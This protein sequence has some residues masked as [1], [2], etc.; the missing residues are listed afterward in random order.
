[1]VV[2]CNTTQSL[3][4]H[5]F[6]PQ[7]PLEG[8]ILLGFIPESLRP[9][10]SLK[11]PVKYNW[12]KYKSRC[13]IDELNGA[14]YASGAYFAATDTLVLAQAGNLYTVVPSDK[15]NIFVMNWREIRL[16]SAL[17]KLDDRQIR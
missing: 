2:V 14:F 11:S 13:R 5:I 4:R 8:N 17:A 9:S 7:F 1:M 15:A 6:G 3:G 12:T 10:R 16:H